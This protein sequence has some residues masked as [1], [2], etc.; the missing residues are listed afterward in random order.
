[1]LKIFSENTIQEVWEKGKVVSGWD[2]SKRRKDQCGAWI[3]R[4]EHGN[5][6]SSFGWEI[7]HISPSGSDA[8]HNLRPLQWK[9]NVV[10]SDGRLTCSII[11]VGNENKKRS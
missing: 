1:M 3:R 10:T 7:D 4:K 11:A 2:P 6:D 8:L 5:R 9:N